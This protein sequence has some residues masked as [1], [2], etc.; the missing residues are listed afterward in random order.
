M[1]YIQGLKQVT[2]IPT[3]GFGLQ[4]GAINPPLNGG[5]MNAFDAGDRLHAQSFEALPDGALNLLL[6]RFKVVEGR[7]KRSQ[8]V[9]R[10]YRQ[11]MTKTVWP[12]RRV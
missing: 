9:F 1:V 6:R 10:R 12:L 3:S 4:T 7:P 5:R 2:A 11:R 8:K